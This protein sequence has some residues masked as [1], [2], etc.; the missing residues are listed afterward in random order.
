MMMSSGSSGGSVM[1]HGVEDRA[2]EMKA[3]AASETP[4]SEAELDSAVKSL[5]NVAGP[6]C[7]SVDWA[8]YRLL[9]SLSAHT[10]HKD[11]E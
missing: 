4:F 8:A 11:W 2:A 9:L 10:T 5:Q 1:V 7:H 3:A 6:Y